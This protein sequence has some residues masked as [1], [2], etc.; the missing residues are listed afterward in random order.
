VTIFP[1]TRLRG[2]KKNIFGR[3]AKDIV[4]EALN[5]AR[6]CSQQLQCR[7]Q[8]RI[9]ITPEVR[10]F[11]TE[12]LRVPELLKKLQTSFITLVA[13][14][15]LLHLMLLVSDVEGRKTDDGG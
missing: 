4:D 12:V 2:G 9:V 3:V 7:L 8:D 14:L 13:R 6:R 10:H 1:L 11:I 15:R 5:N